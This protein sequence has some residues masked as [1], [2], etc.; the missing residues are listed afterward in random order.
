MGAPT[1]TRYPDALAAPWLAVRLGIDPARI[2]AMRRDG[3][4]IAVR[5]PGSI[6]W[7]YPAWQ[8]HEGG[9]R[10]GIA[11]IVAAAREG[12]LDDPKLYELLM[13]P[14][15]L[16]EVG[17]R[18]LVDLLLEGPVDDVVSALRAGG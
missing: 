3:E 17:R 11:R 15:G 12:G 8:F 18:R 14:R 7:R 9:V 10:P 4:L 1:Q 6:E 13:S 5:D 2:D 16:H